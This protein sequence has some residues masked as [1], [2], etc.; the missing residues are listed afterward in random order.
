MSRRKVQPPPELPSSDMEVSSHDKDPEPSLRDMMSVLVY[1]KA[2]LG[3][4]EERVDNLTSHRV[5]Q[6][7]ADEPE[8]STT[9]GAER[10]SPRPQT[11]MA[12]ML[13]TG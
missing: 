9:S 11:K 5:V 8:P 12:R 4:T 10:S 1:I 13:F 2:R 3:V 7:L 6:G